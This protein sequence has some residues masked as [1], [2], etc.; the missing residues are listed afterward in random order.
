MKKFIP[1]FIL[2][3]TI[4]NGQDRFAKKGKT[5]SAQKDGVEKMS[6]TSNQFVP[7][8]ISYQGLITKADGS[9]TDDG[10][11]EILFKVYGTADGGEAV[12]S[13]NQEVTVNNGI[14]STILGNT[15]PFTVIPPEAFLELTVAGSTLSPRQV[16]TSVFYSVLS[17]TSAYAKTA[18]YDSLSNLPDLDIYVLKD[19]LGNYATSADLY[20]TLSA[21]Q[22][23]DSNLTDLVEDGLLSASKVEY[24]I[25][26]AGDS[27]QTWISDGDGAGTWGNPASVAADDI[28]IG[29]GNISI[30]TINGGISIV[31]SD[32][33]N[34]TL[35]STITIDGNLMGLTNDS[36]LLTFSRDTL[37]VRGT[38]MASTIGGFAVLDEDD[39]ASDSELQLATQQSIK[40]YADSKQSYNENLEAIG[41][42]EHGDGNFLVSNGSEWTVE[43]DS[44][45][46]ASLGLGSIAM[47]DS[48]N[49]DINGGTI[50][51]TI[52]GSENP[53]VGNFTTVQAESRAYIGDMIIDSGSIT[54]ESG[55][56]SF[57]DET[58]T[59]AG[60]LSSGS[61]STIGNLTLADGSISSASNQIDFGDDDLATTGTLSTGIATL[62]SGSTIGNLTFTDGTIASGSDNISFGNDNLSTNGTLTAGVSTLSSGSEIGDLT[63]SNGSI[64]SSSDAIDFGNDALSTTGTLS[65]GTATLATGSTVGNLTLSDG[66]ITSSS[67]AIDFGNN[68]LT[69]SSTIT[70]NAFAGDGSNITGVEASSMGILAGASPIVLEGES[71]NDFETILSVE[72]PTLSDKTI[73]FPNATG[74]IIT[75]GND[76]A[77]DE[78]GTITSGEWQGTPIADAYI[79]NDI[80]LS[81]ATI[82]NSVI[83]GTTPAAATVTTITT[84]DSIVPDES[85]G[86][87]L[88]TSSAEF[89]DI[90]LADGAVINLGDEQD[91]TLTHV[92]D[93]GIKLNGSSQIQFGDSGT[94]ISQS[95]DGVLDLVSDNEVEINGTTIDMNGAVDISG[96]VTTGSTIT[97]TGSLLPS[98]VDG[99]GLG[100]SSA[101]FSDVFLADGALINLGNN[102]DVTLTHIKDT[103]IKIN[104]ANQI[105]FG[106]SGT[107]ISQSADG[108]LDLVSDNEV[109]INGTTIDMNGVVDISGAVTTG[110]TI[111]TTGSLLP[112]SSDGA[113]LG[114]SSAEFSDVFLA[115]GAV[116][117]LGDNQEVTL[118]HIEDEGLRLNTLSQMQFG[119]SGTKISQSADGVLDLVSDNEVE[120]NGTTIDINGNTT[121]DNAT[122]DFVKVDGTYVGHVDDT[123]LMNLANG[124]L[125]VSGTLAAT[126]FS[127]D[128]SNLTGISAS[129]IKS[130]D[131][132]QGD[133]A[134]N[135]TT[136]SG[137]ININPASGSPVLIDNTINIDGSLIGHADD[138]DLMT[139]ANG[140]V[141][142][143]GTTVVP[144]ADVNGGAIDGVTLG[145]NSAVTQAVVD[146]V[147]IDGALI[148]HTSDTDLMTLADG[149]VTFTG[150]TVVP[151]ADVNGGA[152]DGVT[153]GTNSAVTQAVIDNINLNGVE[154]GHTDDTDLMTLA[155]GSV[156]FTGTTVI[157]TA[158]VNG[159]AI[160]G[161]TLGTSSPITQA[162][163]DNINM[164]G[165]QIGHATDTD[166]MTL[167]NGTLTVAGTVAATTVT[168]DGS[169]LT[170]ITASEMKSDDISQGDAAVTISTSSGAVNINPASGSPI[171]L[172]N[173][174]NIDGSLIGH[175]D[176]TDLMTLADGSV[177]F[178]GSTVIT[179]ADVNGGA[180][181]AVTLGTNSAV[182]QAVID[183][184]NINGAEIGHTL[185][186]DLMTLADGSVTFT[187]STVIT[188]ADVNGGAI[189]AVTLGTNSAVTQAVIDNVSINGSTIGHTDDTDL[190]TL[191][192][193]VATVAGEISVTTLDIGGTD[194]TSTAAELNKLDDVTATTAE[195]NYV[196]V[197]TLGTSEA[198]KAV[199]VD[200][201]G[202]LLIPDSD[203]YKFGAGSDMQLYHDGSDS[204]ITNATGAM[205]VATETS[206]IAVTI[207]HSTSETTIADNLTVGGDAA[208]AGD[209]TI[210]G[211]NITFGNGETISNAT[212]GDFLLTTG[213]QTGALIVKNSNTTDGIA[214]LELVSDNS[215]D[216]GD[217]YELK[218]VNGTFTVT[219]DH[220]T[221]G[222][223]EDTYLTI[224][225][226]STPASSSTTIAGDLTIA[227]DDLT[228]GTNTSGAALIGDGTNYNPVVISGD[229]SIGSNGVAAISSNVIVNADIN[230]SAAI[231][232]SKLA[233]ITT[234]D[235]VSGAAIQVD[236]ATSGTGITL[237]DDDKFLVDDG[238]TTKY[239]NASQVLSYASAT[240]STDIN[241]GT[242][243]GVTLG[244]NSAVTQ[245]VIDNV[246]INGVEIGH[247]SDTDL[248]TLADGSVTF[249]GSTVVPNA[250]INGG[251]IDG[252]TLGTNSAVTQAV[253]DNVN[254][255][256][257]E[258]GHTSDTDLMTLADGSVTFTGSTVVP[259][260]DINGGT[261]DG[262][263]LGTNSAVTQAVIDNVNINGVE[264]GHTSDTDLMTLANGSVTFTGST[265]IA[266]ADVNAGTI[267]GVTLGTNSAVTQAVIDNVNINGAE[268]GH[269]DD[270]DLMTLADG[271]V[272]FTGSTI[273]TSADVNAGTIDGV[274]LGTNSAVTQAV[275]DNINL[276]GATIGHT[277]DTDLMTLASGSVTFTGSTVVPNADINGGTVDGVTLGTNSA[278]TQAVIDNVNINGAT[279]GH[280]S[281]TDLLTLSSGVVTLAGN[282]T[283]ANGES[284]SNATDGDFLF[285]TDV[286]DGALVLKNSNATDGTAKIELVSDNAD[287]A[288]DGYEIKSVNGIFTV[289]SDH[290]SSGTY[291]DTYL[292]IDGNA[293]PASST[294]KIAGD[295]LVD[296]GQ[297]ALTGDTDLITLSSGAVTVAGELSATTL[298]IG[299][300]DITSTATELNFND[301]TSAGTV[302]ASKTVVV[303]AN[304]D[305][306]SF[307]NIT[308]TGELDAG[309]LDVSGNADID[310]I[311]EADAITVNGSSL[312]SVIQ[313]TTVNVATTGTN[314]VITD[315]E[316]TSETNAIVFVANADLDGNSSIGLE[317][318]GDL[319]YNP[320][321]GTVTATAF[322]GDGSNLTGITA[323]TIGT[324]SGAN[325]ISFR[326]TDLAINS[327]TDGQMDINADVTVDIQAPTTALSGDITISGNDISFGNSETISNASD[328]VIAITSA[329][330]TLSGDLTVT[331]ND[332]IFGNGETISNE[333]NGDFLFTTGT[334][335]GAFILKNSNASDGKAAIELVSDNANEVGDGY[336]IQ[337]L[338]GVFTITGDHSTSG[339]YDDTFITVNGN[340]TPASSYTT[341]AGDLRVDGG[342]I[343]IS[344][345]TDL[346]ALA[347]G[348]ATVDGELVVTSLDIGGTD[349][350]ST[351]AELNIIDGNTSATGTTVAGADRVVL[352]DAGTMVQVA[353]TD[354]DTYISGTSKTLTNK[355]LTS[356]VINT[357]TI[358]GNTTFSD[359]GYNFNIASHD[360]TNGLALDG[361][362][363]TSS[364]A[365]LNIVD[366]STSATG[367]TVADA[368]RVVLNDAGTMVQVAMTDIDTYISG[369]SKTLTNKTLTSPVINTPTITGNTT[370]SDG[371]YDFNIASHDGTN[372]LALGG[373]VVNAT[374]DELN[375]YVLNVSLDDI[376]TASSCYVVAP[377]AGTLTRIYSVIDGTTGTADAVITANVNGGSNVSQTLTIANGSNAGDL[378][379]CTPADNHTV[380]AGQYIKLT[381]NGASTNVV[382]AVFSLVITL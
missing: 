360:G 3:L 265:V 377:K 259:N 49:M 247:T 88:G 293:T 264:I 54:S 295:L 109:E 309:S 152:I 255:N 322:V 345:D 269:T 176:D 380:S 374:A 12:W 172:D 195:L 133:A 79:P 28:I 219:S 128:G 297:I 274:T 236:G 191:A 296:G 344:G 127:G 70:A 321:T 214:S 317:S 212:D 38:V 235:K 358:T 160:D 325:A 33:D 175:T 366:G 298:D 134:V 82:D 145:T 300:T 365:E 216:V 194:V 19:S 341:I 46:R 275:V 31:P 147:N 10:S 80:T 136:S 154:I 364:G 251:T 141:T 221:K 37:T 249:T 25:S 143:T 138:T 203:K 282:L 331:G 7:R 50:D 164:N 313:G 47:L 361:T 73:T 188:T 196:D 62:G 263:T 173:T 304:K 368:D 324:L 222:T 306:A 206:G 371:A 144:T 343:G 211:N 258:I 375:T 170:G 162:V 121:L 100:S 224:V 351:P 169:G 45:A 115:D 120:I 257:V 342:E 232:D 98:S 16:L 101:E 339:T 310:G 220:S 157:P 99:A 9:P 130:D 245:A 202:D 320:S 93:T 333:E 316:N 239:V 256:G 67:N 242:I 332:I 102:Q 116:I 125:T 61:G 27:G 20:D 71:I 181:D 262:V 230:A 179:T 254:I 248:M 168:G 346:I 68:T 92:E 376:S 74:T 354:I 330:T 252:V 15:N 267:D 192:N 270:T 90:F 372:G 312:A 44:V 146:N 218:S 373:T 110:S 103:G 260:A 197:T 327:S 338:N 238:G 97:T 77:I 35:D 290:S 271:S 135:I 155:D 126:T 32:G 328:N 314:V 13:E 6:S 201:N 81:G 198:S 75:T 199:T 137:A 279:I 158:D 91:V 186:T 58:I 355:T 193:G 349:I 60:T 55:T 131:I 311:L 178:T 362:V 123:D 69:T 280:T 353:M 281:D 187:G 40:A 217:G 359:G 41:S 149:S 273:I 132:S 64:T 379:D 307:R 30:Q 117:N 292:T 223:Y 378:D 367:T 48:D 53:Q 189:D 113:G 226:N 356:P 335:N 105:Q 11:Y 261:I 369:T 163:I 108:V 96:A 205:K 87:T 225:G 301:G 348:R 140:S 326:D 51:G 190:L 302:V 323:S 167:S 95:A 347:S 363:V 357:P 118:T 1:I 59:T 305:I 124:T 177:T 43:S 29:D 185:D 213:T 288:G 86:A 94:Q 52:I 106:D 237:A 129:S 159:G 204:Y 150:T 63:I 5:V 166:L 21:Y 278:V 246:N 184:V 183:N 104:D 272:T 119:D 382:S 291:N 229:L 240:S 308:L 24:G 161:V 277:S 340:S 139:L 156:T 65:T 215:G 142:F 153:L 34:I 287:N 283:F 84:N 56:V 241:G 57:D 66:S 228:M 284:V 370:F 207:G 250:D 22:K 208:V 289:T 243:D 112:A 165:A 122:I 2:L 36:D 336:E 17:D 253:I 114:S 227:G 268:I 286:T 266:S 89:S 76:S 210:T 151:T 209:V 42:L 294:T 78:V 299:G 8:R 85:D 4:V 111:T 329:S 231:A 244:T 334:A 233:T 107:Q 285:T 148:G 174:I 26:S 18:N 23:L 352:N 315:N 276:N 180:I 171:L 72:D 303:D 14:I 337:S 200:A 182:T 350:T 83:G 319:H 381:T 234:A 39:M 318:D